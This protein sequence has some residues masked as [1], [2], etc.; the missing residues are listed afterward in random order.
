MERIKKL[1]IGV[2]ALL[3]MVCQTAW[4]I[5]YVSVTA[6]KSKITGVDVGSGYVSSVTLSVTLGD[7]EAPNGQAQLRLSGNE[8]DLVS[9]GANLLLDDVLMQDASTK[10]WKITWSN[11]PAGTY[12]VYFQQLSGGAHTK[13]GTI[14]IKENPNA[15]LDVQ[16]EQSD[17]YCDPSHPAMQGD[18]RNGAV[19]VNVLGGKAPFKYTAIIFR[20]D[21]TQESKSLSSSSRAWKI[22]GLASGERVKVTVVDATNQS[23]AKTSS[24]INYAQV[25]VDPYS[26]NMIVWSGDC[27]FDVYVHLRIY[28]E[29]KAALEAQKQLLAKTVKIVPIFG[30]YEKQELACQYEAAFDSVDNRNSSYLHVYFKIPRHSVPF[31]NGP[32]SIYGLKYSTL[33]GGDYENENF[34]HFTQLDEATTLGYESVGTVGDDCVYQDKAYYVKVYFEGRFSHWYANKGKV[35]G[36]L[37]KKNAD[38]TYP[39]T[40]TY[41]QADISVTQFKDYAAGIKV[42]TPG[43]YKL[44]LGDPSCPFAYYTG[45]VNVKEPAPQIKT[46]VYNHLGIHGN[47][48]GVQFKVLNTDRMPYEVTIERPDGK[49]T[50]EVTDFL[51]AR[52]YTTNISFPRTFAVDES[53][54]DQKDTHETHAE[55]F[56]IGDLPAGSYKLKLRDQCGHEGETTFTIEEKDLIQYKPKQTDGYKDGVYLGLNCAKQPVVKFDFGVQN[57]HAV[58]DTKF[59]G[60]TIDLENNGKWTSESFGDVKDFWKEPKVG[61][62]AFCYADI[63]PYM[64]DN[65]TFLYPHLTL[66]DAIHD[67]KRRFGVSGTADDGTKD[68]DKKPDTY[69][70][71]TYRFDFN[72]MAE[73]DVFLLRGTIC[74]RLDTKAGIVGVSIKKGVNVSYP[75]KYTLYKAKDGQRSGSPIKTYTANSSSAATDVAWTGLEQG[76]YVVNIVYGSEECGQDYPV[77][78]KLAD[79]PMPSVEK[80]DHSFEVT[81]K[82]EVDITDGMTPRH[83]YLPVSPYIYNVEWYDVTDGKNDKKGEGNELYASFTEPG[84][85]TYQIRTTLTSKT[86][87]E[88][89]SGGERFVTFYVTKKAPKPNYWMG[90]TSECFDDASNWTANKVPE[91]KETIEF[92]TVDNFGKAAE[93]DCCLKGT[94]G[95]PL[96]F[97][98]GSLINQSQKAMVVPAGASLQVTGGMR[99]FQH[100]VNDPVRLRIE[101]SKDA[102]PNGAFTC[103]YTGADKDAVYAEVQMN[104][105]SKSVKEEWK[106]DKIVGSPTA[107]RTFYVD[108]T[109]QFFGIPF[110][111]MSASQFSESLIYRYDE[112]HNA[113]RSYYKKFVGLKRGVEMTAFSGYDIRRKEPTTFSLKGFLHLGDAQLVMSRRASAVAGA[114]GAY[115]H[116]GL[117]QNIFGNSYTAP[118]KVNA[119]DFPET[120]AQTVYLYRT[121]SVKDWGDNVA[122]GN[123]KGS[124]LALP[125]NTAVA[126]GTSEIPSM[127]GFLVR[128]KDDQMT[129]GGDDAK[130]TIR[131]A[132]QVAPKATLVQMAKP[133][134][135]TEK[136][137]P[138]YVHFR[139]HGDTFADEMWLFEQPGTSMAY[140]DGWDGDK[141]G[142]EMMDNL[143]YSAVSDKAYQVNTTDC[144]VNA[145][146]T[147]QT[148]SEDHCTL[149]LTRHNLPQYPDLKLVD[150][151]TRQVISFEGSQLEYRFI[152]KPQATSY[153]RF[154]LVNTKSNDF[155][156][157]VTKLDHVLAENLQGAAVLYDLTG[158]E[159]VR[160][161]SVIDL[162]SASR[163]L[164]NGVYILKVGTGSEQL[165]RKIVIDN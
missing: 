115:V 133:F 150:M 27:D 11:V 12:D 63:T 124:Y 77:E 121:G 62:I 37:Y 152:A 102:K 1:R 81:D 67:E 101:A 80:S 46:K 68:A 163:N 18:T 98:A 26:T 38:G 141:L 161:A 33:C 144:L 29:N 30:K 96:S 64:Y 146:I 35:Y 4:S 94:S 83:V 143:I 50:F 84:V 122:S 118:I 129:Y 14:T 41:T 54:Y 159:I 107:G 17:A 74:D 128:F 59:E 106:D 112:T 142:F 153:N 70:R 162:N 127:Q 99:G 137:A 134:E 100:E 53:Y 131:Y 148:A 43:T 109:D 72:K 40:P 61:S 39:D 60:R 44:V 97:V 76:N 31:E 88:G 139:L 93:R 95:M 36:K 66:Y 92:A 111:T 73:Q 78:I 87:C 45:E 108:Y 149:R 48:A 6:D 125:K 104:A 51:S 16:L 85:Y 28:T 151:I 156:T 57:R 126:Q 8:T 130:M 147:V 154:M 75:L 3:V 113:D 13:L 105:L 157:I 24:S 89:S 90:G 47:T 123:G 19:M 82:I 9:N 32:G 120:V 52:K 136:A 165:V 34:S 55:Y 25:K 10:Q 7:G 21:G 155:G 132:S 140:D 56:H 58:Y 158:V 164:T 20:N 69:Y 160:L 65:W 110:K 117:G 22:D 23:L 42:G 103:T 71:K 119:L 79:I 15:K 138:G 49:T 5:N 145:N 114:T 135:V 91:A 2:L 116:W 86:N